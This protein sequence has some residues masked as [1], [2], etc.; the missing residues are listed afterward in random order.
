MRIK[1]MTARVL[2]DLPLVQADRLKVSHYTRALQEGAFDPYPDGTLSGGTLSQNSG[3]TKTELSGAPL[4][5]FDSALPDH[6]QFAMLSALHADDTGLRDF[7][8]LFDRRLL[9]LEM[10]VRRASVLVATQ[11]DQGCSP[12]SILSR[13][14]RMIKRSPEDT[15]YLKLLM[16]LLSRSRS[17]EGLREILGWWT[18]SAVSVSARFDTLRPIDSDSLSSLSSFSSLSSLSSLSSCRYSAVALGQGALLGRFGR[19]PMGHIS[20]RITCADRAA[21]DAL[22]GDTQ[23]LAELRSVT[24][25]Y[26]RD[27]VPVSFYA[28]IMRRCLTAPRLSA[29]PARA[30]RLGAYNLLRPEHRPDARASIKI[31]QISA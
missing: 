30:D 15:R 31:T 12:V 19:T 20:V 6:I 1:D 9:A 3:I 29:H 4:T 23:A 2:I 18:G 24:M 7:L 14:L 27:P 26:L 25:Q 10:R 11:D 22:I 21:L 13:L 16:P 8:S 28:T 5:S 17:L